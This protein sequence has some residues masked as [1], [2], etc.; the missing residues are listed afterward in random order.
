MSPALS[1]DTSS[2]VLL[3][4]VGLGGLVRLFVGVVG[5]PQ[6]EFVQPDR[7]LL[8]LGPPGVVLLLL[9]DLQ[10]DGL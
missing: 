10:P 9:P 4:A 2:S 7:A 5:G 1:T 3:S 8:P 6:A